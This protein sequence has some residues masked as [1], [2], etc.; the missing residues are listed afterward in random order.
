MAGDGCTGD[1]PAL[2]PSNAS[3]RMDWSFLCCENSRSTLLS[4]FLLSSSSAMVNA[5]NVSCFCRIFDWKFRLETDC[6]GTLRT[7]QGV[8]VSLFGPAYN[9]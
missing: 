7:W 4:T 2:N 5:V 3:N 8:C 1:I 6:L 9:L